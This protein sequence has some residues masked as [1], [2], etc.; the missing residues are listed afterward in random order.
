L[1]KKLGKVKITPKTA[2]LEKIGVGNFTVAEAIAELVANCFD[3]R[4]YSSDSS[5]ENLAEPL[6]VRITLMQDSICILD[7]ASGMNQE[8]LG[9]ALTMAND[10]DAITGKSR[11]RM[12]LFGLGMKSASSSLGRNWCITT[13]DVLTG[14]TYRVNFDLVEFSKQ[15]SWEA[16][17]EQLEDTDYSPLNEYKSGTYIEITKLRTGSPSDG[18]VVYFLGNAFKPLLD[19]DKNVILIND[20]K[21]SP[22]PYNLVE[23]SRRELEIVIDESKG[24]IV[25]GWAGLDSITHNDGLYGFNLFRNEQLIEQWNKDFFRAH[26]M[27]SRVV[28]ELHLNFI[29]TNFHKQGFSQSS[30]AWKITASKLRE[31]LK[32]FSKASQDM[33]GTKNDPGKMAKAIGGIDVAFHKI[34]ETVPGSELTNPTDP[35]DNSKTDSA[36]VNPD[37]KPESQ[38]AISRNFI[39]LNGEEIHLQATFEDF[40]DE[41]VLWDFIFDE[42]THELQAVVNETSKLFSTVKDPKFLAILA[43]ADVVAKFLISKRGVKFEN[44]MEFRDKWI[45][46]AV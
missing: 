45:L 32:P 19:G 4:I 33:V 29:E 23:H 35:E 39:R 34:P 3:A 42:E 41:N 27:N 5:G 40:G 2:L 38:D 21:V 10:M 43:L 8:V 28:G 24:W 22:Q 31:E 26:T 14:N 36:E 6:E 15:E 30:E 25:T 44:A 46:E 7:N 17:I 18:A 16:E 11:T 9:E 37:P 12:G 20:H 1:T 13:K